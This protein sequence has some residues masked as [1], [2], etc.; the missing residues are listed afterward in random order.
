MTTLKDT[1]IAY[2]SRCVWWD[3]IQKTGKGFQGL[4]CCPHCKGLLFEVPSMEQWQR[5]IDEYDKH[6]P[7]YKDLMKWLQ[8]KCFKTIKDAKNA[9]LQAREVSNG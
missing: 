2:G 5:G 9:I 6:N 1:R 8:G 7:G 3:N 4:P